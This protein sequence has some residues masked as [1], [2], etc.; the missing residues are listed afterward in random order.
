[1]LS[2][3]AEGQLLQRVGAAQARQNGGSGNSSVQS[4]GGTSVEVL[5]GWSP[6]TDTR[7]G[8]QNTGNSAEIPNT[9]GTQAQEVTE[10]STSVNTDPSK[11]T[12]EEQARIEEYQAA[13][14]ENFVSYIENVQKNPGAKI[15]RYFLKPVSERAAEAV[16]RLTGIDVSGNKT[17]I[18]PRIVQHILKEHGSNGTTDHSMQDINDIARI[19]YVLDNYDSVE[20]AGTS[21]AYV[22]NKE[23]GKH[24]NAQTVKFSKAV[25]GTYY[26][27]EA[28]PDTSKKIVYI[29]TAY[30]T[31]NQQPH[32][33]SVPKPLRNAQSATMNPA[34]SEEISSN[35]N[36]PNHSE[37]VNDPQPSSLTNSPSDS[38][39]N[40]YLKAYYN[41]L[42]SATSD[43]QNP[44]AFPKTL[45][46]RDEQL[47][48]YFDEAW[49]TEDFVSPL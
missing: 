36:I 35:L 10:E 15:G 5:Q 28:V 46:S 18:E 11:H 14:D 47:G 41:Y 26:V 13:V 1:M 16:K 40:P 45:L 37:N 9:T 17:A 19:Q 22:T 3:Q 4:A 44:N 23:N 8:S 49:D 48:R 43:A 42:N 31:K 34:G 29:V 32:R 7:T 30:M 39:L 12:P 24:A 20:A 33:P 25:N 21:A 38:I 2:N 6:Q 27:V